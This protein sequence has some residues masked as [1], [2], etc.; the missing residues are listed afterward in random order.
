MPNPNQRNL[1]ISKENSR[2]LELA[3]SKYEEERGDSNWGDFLSYMAAGF[4]VGVGV[5]AIARIIENAGGKTYE[6]ECPYTN[7]KKLIRIL[8]RGRTPSA[9]ATTCPWCSNEF[10]IRYEG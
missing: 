4:L 8:V 2:L 10:V 5:V 3:K 6:V 7:C 9:E 1:P